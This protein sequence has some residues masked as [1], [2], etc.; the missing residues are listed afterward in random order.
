[1]LQDAHTLSNE[2]MMRQ[3]HI[4]CEITCDDSPSESSYTIP[5]ERRSNR[6]STESSASR[7][8]SAWTATNDT[9]QFALDIVRKL[10]KVPPNKRYQ[11]EIDIEMKILETLKEAGQ[12][13]C[14]Q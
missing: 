4:K 9:E 3:D 11:L 2:K 1:M 8:C 12:E 5:L 13:G 7:P 10:D 6:L 14:S